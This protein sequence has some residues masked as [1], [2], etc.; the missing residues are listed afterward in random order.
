MPLS[1]GEQR[2]L[3]QMERALHAEDPKLATALKQGNQTILNGRKFALGILV[4]V[5]GIGALIAGVASKLIPVGVLGFVIMLVGV[6]VMGRAFKKDETEGKAK[7]D[8]PRV[9]KQKS[10]SAPSEGFMSKMEERWRRRNEGEG[11]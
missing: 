3:E 10:A 9:T 1:E 8:P 6:L 11:F 5:I 2:I 4:L 7:A